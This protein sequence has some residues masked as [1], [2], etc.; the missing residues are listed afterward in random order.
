MQPPAGGC[1]LSHAQVVINDA[2]TNGSIRPTGAG[3]YPL[4]VGHTIAANPNLLVVVGVSM[5]IVNGN[6]TTSFR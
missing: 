1:T 6:P 3:N 5:N 2:T 4:T